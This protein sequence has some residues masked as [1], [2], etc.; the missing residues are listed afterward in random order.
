[1]LVL[2]GLAAGQRPRIPQSRIALLK[3]LG[4]ADAYDR[5]AARHQLI[6]ERDKTIESLMELARSKEQEVYIQKCARETAFELLGSYRA[7]EARALLIE[8]IEY[9]SP[10]VSPDDFNAL[11]YY[12]AARALVEIG[13][14]AGPELLMA[15]MGRTVN[16]TELKLFAYV[17][18]LDCGREVGLLRIQRTLEECRKER[19]E[20]AKRRGIEIDVSIREKN[21]ARLIEV[22]KTVQPND[23][24][25]WPRPAPLKARK[26][27][28]D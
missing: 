9:T 12:P 10:Y 1:M 16:N 17:V 15:R 2:F 3:Q 25:D 28:V 5:E 23:P 22:Y 24:A 14:A 11:L 8:E 4:S 6:A 7:R 18:W 13:D 20:Y 27:Q 26:T 21:L 19:E